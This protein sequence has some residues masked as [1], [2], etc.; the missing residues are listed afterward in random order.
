MHNKYFV[1]KTSSS[2]PKYIGFNKEPTSEYE[3]HPSDKIFG[4]DYDNS[5]GGVEIASITDE[6]GELVLIE[7]NSESIETLKDFH[8]KY[9]NIT[10]G[11]KLVIGNEYSNSV[12]KL[13]SSVG[14][15][16]KKSAKK[17][18]AKKSAKKTPA[19]K[20][21]KKTPA[22]K[23]AKKT[24]AKLGGGKKKKSKKSKK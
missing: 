21:A 6:N 1:F 11:I 13:I 12:K 4:L 17:T 18:P 20:S 7:N 16:A 9:G 5:V 22:K 14:N 8:E 10:S 2:P 19:K 3:K 15:T 24:P 23:S